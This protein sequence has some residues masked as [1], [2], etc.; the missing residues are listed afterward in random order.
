MP[1]VRAEW[2]D[3][4]A[5]S[6]LQDGHEFIID[7]SAEFGG[8]D[9]GPRP[10]NLLMTALAGCTGMDVVSILRKMKIDDYRLTVE[11]QGE[12]TEEH[13]KIFRSLNIRY[14]FDGD[15]LPP[16]KIERAVTLSQEKYCGVTAILGESVDIGF[17]IVL[18]DGND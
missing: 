13:P 14:L 16:D 5:F 15:Y 12:Y 2:R 11:V 9:L 7:G 6:V 17:E 3:G 8:Q 10:K 18:N 4:L 1:S